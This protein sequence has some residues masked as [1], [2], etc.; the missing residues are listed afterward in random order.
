MAE[1]AE[2]KSRRFGQFLVV[3]VNPYL[4]FCLQDTLNDERHVCVCACKN[5]KLVSVQLL[6]FMMVNLVISD[7]VA[8]HLGFHTLNSHF[9]ESTASLLHCCCMF[10]A[11]LSFH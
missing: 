1:S 7:L 10:V 5:A 3:N 9:F 8:D 6:H 2:T 4:M 11:F